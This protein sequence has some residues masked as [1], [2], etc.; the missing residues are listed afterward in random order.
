MHFD[1]RSFL[2]SGGLALAGTATWLG[3]APPQRALSGE[4]QIRPVP[5]VTVAAERITR[6]IAGLRPFRPSGF[7]V[8]AES[9][10]E[11]LAIHNYGHGG[12]GVTLSWG[13]ADMAVRQALATPHRQAAVIGCG[14]VGLTTARLL[15][16]RGFEVAI[17]A[18]ELPPNTTSN[19]AAAM[20]GVT[21][22]VDSAHQSGPFVAELQS[23]A[24]F[25]HRYFQN[26]IGERYGVRWV[27]MYLIGDDP[28]TQP[29]EFAITPELYPFTTFKPGEH[30]FPVPHA[31]SFP[32]MMI[33]S[34]VFLAQLLSDFL[35]RGGELH[36]Q[37]FQDRA[38]LVALSA[39]LIVNCTGLGAKQLFGDPELTPVKGQ[40]TLLLPQ[41]EVKYAYLDGRRDLYMFP[42][43][44]AIIL[45]GSHEESVWSTEPDV[46]RAEEILAGH[47]ALSAGMR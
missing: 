23:A 7:M 47:A 40:L 20:F 45:G 26:F 29:W 13:T 15:Q 39:P 5:K 19:I 32:T 17:Y 27:D 10:G 30:P 46:K 41:S 1:R 21:S 4:R 14:A 22:I 16:D 11:K 25:A 34:G 3:S 24:R 6:Q 31:S 2:R 35:I 33:E 36:I 38:S 8:G 42:R 9:L 44:D 28:Q 37:A 12:C 18:K 43:S